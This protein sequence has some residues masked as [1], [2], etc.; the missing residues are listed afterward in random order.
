[1]ADRLSAEFTSLT[2]L[3]QIPVGDEFV[4]DLIAVQNSSRKRLFTDPQIDKTVNK[5]FDKIDDVGDMSVTDYQDMSSELKAKARQA[6]K[7]DSPDPYFGE[8]LGELVDALD[9][10]A[11]NN[12]D[13]NALTRLKKAR[14]QWRAL[15]VLEK[16]RA[17]HESGDISGP[18]LANYLRRTDKG[19]YG[20]G[21]NTSDIYEAARLSKAFPSRPDSGTASRQF[22]NNLLQNPVSGGVGLAMSPLVST[23]S[24]AFVRGPGAIGRLSGASYSPPLMAAG[25]LGGGALERDEEERRYR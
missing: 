4:D 6:W 24:N 3:D 5:I 18:L 25:R 10:L 1:M 19:G 14:A 13:P 20:R 15:S 11:M 21:K 23:L 9:E 12:V 8:S 7:G 17:V 22:I 16:S 2:D